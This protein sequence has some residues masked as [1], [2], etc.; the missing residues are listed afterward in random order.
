MATYRSEG[1]PTLWVQTEEGKVWVEKV[2]DY[3]RPPRIDE[4]VGHCAV[5][6]PDGKVLAET[7][8]AIRVLETYHPPCVYFPRADVQKD[9]LELATGKLTICEYKG[10]AFYFAAVGY[11]FRTVAWTY[12]EPLPGYEEIAGYIS[13]YPHVLRC[14]V[15]EDE[16]RPQGGGY[17]GGWIYPGIEGPFKGDPGGP[18]TS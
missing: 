16:V 12:P 13:F 4:M 1:G 15:D 7:L 6:L 5:A 18:E 9:L 11:P 2:A 8:N 10:V 3:P 14:T 17:Y